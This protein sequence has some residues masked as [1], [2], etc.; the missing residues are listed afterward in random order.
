M[1]VSIESPAS[2]R[3][4]GQ[5]GYV[6]LIVLVACGIFGLIVMS[7]LAMVG[8]DARASSAYVNSDSA[9]RALDGALQLGIGQVKAVPS[10]SLTNPTNPCVG[11]PSGSSVAIEGRQVDLSCA[12]AT[13]GAP[14]SIPSAGDGASVLTLLREWDIGAA[15]PPMLSDG[16]IPSMGQR[17]KTGL[18]TFF[19]ASTADNPGLIHVAEEPLRIYGS[20]NVRQWA[21]T[22]VPSTYSSGIAV[23]GG[24]YREGDVQAAV[25]GSADGFFALIGRNGRASAPAGLAC[26]VGRDNVTPLAGPNYPVPVPTS[27]ARTTPACV[28]GG[29][30]AFD[31]GAYDQT[32]IAAMNQLFS[33]GNCDGVTFWFKPGEYFLAAAP[34]YTI[35][36][37]YLNDS[38]SNFVFGAPMGWTAA[39][40][41]PVTAF[42]EACDRK[43]QGVSIV[44]GATTSIVHG[45]GAVSMCGRFDGATP[46]NPVPVLSQLPAATLPASTWSTEPNL[47]VGGYAA[48]QVVGAQN[49]AASVASERPATYS[50]SG[51]PYDGS[52]GA[53]AAQRLTSDFYCDTA[54]ARSFIFTGWQTAGGG[55]ERA[56]TS[57]VVKIRATTSNVRPEYW[58]N[59]N[60]GDSRTLVYFTR[61]DGIQCEALSS[62]Y[63]GTS[64]AMPLAIDLLSPSAT[65]TGVIRDQRDLENGKIEIYFMLN[66][67]WAP[68]GILGCSAPR[69]TMSLDYVWIDTTTAASPSPDPTPMAMQID[70][71]NNRSINIFGRVVLP[72]TQIDVKWRGNPSTPPAYELPII[73]GDVVARGMISSTPDQYSRHIGPLA[74]RTLVPTSRRVRIQAS[75]GGQLLASTVVELSDVDPVAPSVIA[76]A[77]TLTTTDWNYCNVPLTPTAKC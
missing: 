14:K 25:C 69:L 16:E 32:Q 29:V 48:S 23:L 77:R 68:C 59:V 46:P 37:V 47:S 24:T 35:G 42:P 71:A 9:K 6:L 54:C 28:P 2:V 8:T 45:N 11:F 39:G 76:G 62:N 20:V 65:C 30:V 5:D 41:A 38:T 60:V 61:A 64:M 33:E 18:A 10:A 4:R 34:D 13:E 51:K 56:M 1:T 22:S 36:A 17:I 15:V 52:D 12:D 63:P 7:L 3:R 49:A 19:Q 70:A 72:R 43:A 53:A 75:V 31:P 27:T 66:G 26:G 73:V 44:L 21:L 67:N 55:S 40:R 74:S 58:W 50:A 57:A